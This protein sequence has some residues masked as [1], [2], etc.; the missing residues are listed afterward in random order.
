MVRAEQ[1]A[2]YPALAVDLAVWYEQLE[3]RFRR[4]DHSAQILQNKFW[5]RNVALI[6]GSLVATSLGA[7]LTAVG[8]KLGWLVVTQV[9][10][11]AL[12]AQLAVLIRFGRVRQKY[13]TDRLK[14]ESIKS[15]FYLFL[16]RVGDY[17][18]GDPV[19]KLQQQVTD[20]EEAEGAA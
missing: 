6:I 7:V 16:A 17:A 10:F 15:E 2:E 12:L 3:P 18:A 20:I 11:T 8:G 4:L 19:T 5:R 13:L 14:A 1:L 9:A